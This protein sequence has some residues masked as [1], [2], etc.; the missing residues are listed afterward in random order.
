[1]T[2]IFEL[3]GYQDWLNQ[4]DEEEKKYVNKIV[5]YF[6]YFDLDDVISLLKKLY[7]SLIDIHKISLEKTLFVSVGYLSN[8]GAAVSNYFCEEN[9]INNKAFIALKDISASNLQNIEYLVFFDAFIGTGKYLES[10]IKDLNIRF[11]SKQLKNIKIICASIVGYQQGIDYLS[12]KD[13]NVCVA[14]E[15][16][17]KFQ[18]FYDKSNLLME[19]EK[20]EIE[21][22]IKSH[23]TTLN[24]TSIYANDELIA[25]VSFFFGTPNNTLPF[26]WETAENWRP[27]FPYGSNRE[28]HSNIS[29]SSKFIKDNKISL[30]CFDDSIASNNEI[31]K[32]LFEKFHA[33]PNMNIIARIINA[34]KINSDELVKSLVN[35]IE[36]LQG[37]QHENKSVCTSIL[38]INPDYNNKIKQKLIAKAKDLS[39]FDEKKVKSNILIVD[40]WTRTLAFNNEGVA[41]GIINYIQEQKAETQSD[42]YKA[43]KAT[44][45]FYEGLLIIFTENNRILLYFNGER[46]M[47]KKAKDWHIHSNLKSIVSTNMLNGIRQEVFEKAIYFALKLSDKQEGGMLCIG[48]LDNVRKFARP[49]GNLEFEFTENNILNVDEECF[50]S[51]VAQDGATLIDEQ[52]NVTDYLMRLVPSSENVEAEQN[53]GT[54]HNSAKNMSKITNAIYIVISADGPI[55]IYRGGEKITQIL[56]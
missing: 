16:K 51:C 22:I 7:L 37:M 18:L 35:T 52:G 33:L 25:L 6:Y 50:L 41:L 46:L 55:S 14:K 9:G 30:T 49:M 17:Y 1:M 48:D 31:T 4:F 45:K 20:Q 38:I 28:G 10:L 47:T 34:L 43:L 15:I 5:T 56:E 23:C 53:K 54:R 40:G 21:K 29:E 2:N 12:A 32:I 27:L 42:R 11:G 8:N 44:S 13:I 19:N 36:S 24:E 26:F 3:E 39:I